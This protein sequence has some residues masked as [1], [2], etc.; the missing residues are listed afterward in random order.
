MSA[1]LGPCPWCGFTAPHQHAPDAK[2]H[3]LDACAWCGATVDL[4]LTV[5]HLTHGYAL[6]CSDNLDC[7]R[8][9]ASRRA[10]A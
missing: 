10:A 4:V 1:T 3:P 2:Y 5:H 7:L 9:M 8:R 6:R